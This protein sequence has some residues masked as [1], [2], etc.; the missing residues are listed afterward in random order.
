MSSDPADGPDKAAHTQLPP[1]GETP[2]PVFKRR[3]RYSGKNPRRFEDKYKEL[4]PDKYPDAVAKVLAAGKTPA[5]QHVPIMVNE[6]LQCLRPEPGQHAVDCTL[7]YG[8]HSRAIWERLQPGGHLLSL[9]ADPL[10]LA[11]TETRLRE[12]GLGEYSFTALRCNFAGLIKAVTDQGWHEGA[13]VIFADLGLSSMQI[14]NPER[15]F[16]FKH[17]GPLDMRLNPQ[18]GKSAAELLATVSEERLTALLGENADEPRASLLARHLITT[19]RQNPLVRTKAFAEAIRAALPR[20]LPAEEAD[21]TV[22][23]VFQAVRIEVNEE[24]TVLDGLLRSL[25]AALKPGGRVAIL[26]FHSGEDRRVKKAFQ[27]GRNLGFYSEISR[28]VVRASSEEQRQNPR[29]T[30]AK[31]RWAIRA[32]S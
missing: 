8:G 14:D 5:G 13:E 22:R 4:N 28:D 16:T 19:R 11:K 24:F 32:H 3:K 18:R 25:P 7:G 27:E 31:L 29:S 26:T 10:E 21:A 30:P 17:D 15:G 2:A 12:A 9:D 20:S 6:V 23:R 1:T